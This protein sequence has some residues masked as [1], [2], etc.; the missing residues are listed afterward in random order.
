MNETVA[1]SVLKW[2]APRW[3][4]ECDVSLVDQRSCNLLNERDQTGTIA[5]P[6]DK[7]DVLP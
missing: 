3:P 4:N 6:S 2:I 1:A 5:K 7:S